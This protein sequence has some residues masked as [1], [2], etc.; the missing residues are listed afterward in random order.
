M[1]ACIF[2]TAGGIPGI[3]PKSTAT[4]GSGDFSAQATSPQS[5]LLTWKAVDGATAYN[6][7]YGWNGK[8]FHPLVEL[9]PSQTQYEDFSALPN[10]T[11]SYR[12]QPVTAA[13]AGDWLRADATV[14]AASPHPLTVSPTYDDAHTVSTTVGMAGGSISLTDA[15]G[16]KYKLDIP[17]GALAN[18]TQI[19]LVPLTG[20]DGW[21]LDGERLATIRI[22]PGG[23]RLAE[24]ATLSI[25][26]RSIGKPDLATVGFAFQAMGTEFHLQPLPSS[27]AGK[28]SL[29]T[30]G[31]QPVTVALQ[32]AHVITLP[33][34]VLGANGVGQGSTGAITDLAKND[35]PTDA[36]AAADQQQAA[37]EAYQD[38]LAPLVGAPPPSNDLNRDAAVRSEKDMVKI[39][40]QIDEANDGEALDTAMQQFQKWDQDTHGLTPDQYQSLTSTFWDDMTSKFMKLLEKAAEDCKNSSGTPPPSGIVPFQTMVDHALNPPTNDS[41]W[42][43]FK[44]KMTSAFGESVLGQAWFNLKQGVCGS[45]KVVKP[46]GAEGLICSLARPFN[47]TEKTPVSDTKIEF[48]PLT[49]TK[50]LVHV[51][52]TLAGAQATFT[53]VG[54]YEVVFY[55][56]K[57]ANIQVEWYGVYQQPGLMLPAAKQPPLHYD[58][59]NTLAV[60]CP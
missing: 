39:W 34:I 18:D 42:S 60:D 55:S 59:Q 15:G 16:V 46:F 6:L 11:L 27:Q 12:L 44:S 24:A 21:P 22:E 14:P 26:L 35:P 51:H 8:D 7:E 41:Q 19:D 37:A 3:G 2:G 47:I 5:V 20:M 38:D 53:G 25:T 4:A 31:G 33:V 1:V 40:E 23:L 58:L 30:S 57:E 43:V 28:T 50:G 49:M 32:I 10:V 45:Y 56:P 29:R 13:G 48:F 52:M 9:P 17:A 36:S 54:P